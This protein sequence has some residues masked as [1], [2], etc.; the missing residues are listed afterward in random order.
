MKMEEDKIISFIKEQ[1]SS[2]EKEKVLR[3]LSESPENKEKYYQLKNLWA[4]TI[5]F[6]SP[7]EVDEKEAAIFQKN[8]RN[9][10]NERLR[11]RISIF[12]RYAAV[13][14]IAFF[15]GK[16][17]FKTLPPTPDTELSYNEISVPPGQM[18]QVSLSDGTSVFINSCSKL[19]YPAKFS[20]KERRVFLSGEAFFEVQKGRVPFLVETNSRVVKVLGT[21]FNIMTYPND[22]Y[23]QTT[24]IEGKIVL[25]D[26]T[27][28][29][30]A[31]LKPG[32]QYS[33]THLTGNY[34]IKLVKTDIYAS[35]KDGIYV[36]D[37]ET[38]GGLAKRLERIFAVK[39]YIQNKRIQNYKFTGTISRNVPFE[40]I[41][42][43]IQFSAPVRYKL[44][45]THNAIEEVTLY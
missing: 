40:Q 45:E 1:Q 4:L 29:Q 38:L 6:D 44:K 17:I 2:E 32:E 11:T 30:I 35:W 24:L 42:K 27:G 28:N 21:K 9:K 15:S 34:T 37:H 3:W 23:Y 12:L 14:L 43:I 31:E 26:T 25:S 7:I 36:F 39:I 20:L 5:P 16:Y 22:K 13:V 19:R 33:L 18:A 8:I 10:K 41:L